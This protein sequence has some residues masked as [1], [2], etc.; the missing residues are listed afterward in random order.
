M[1][2]KIA[3]AL[4]RDDRLRTA[5]RGGHVKIWLSET[6]KIERAQFLHASDDSETDRRIEEVIAAMP[7]LPEA[8]PKEM[9]RV[10]VMRVGVR[11]GA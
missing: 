7:P 9:P 6:G 10:V 3:D 4:Q 1:M 2:D 5:K 8:P 11:P